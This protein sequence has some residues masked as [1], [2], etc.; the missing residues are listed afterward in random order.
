MG[1]HSFIDRVTTTLKKWEA[2]AAE[3]QAAEEAS[4]REALNAVSDL[5][6][7][8]RGAGFHCSDRQF[9][10]FRRACSDNQ[11][12]KIVSFNKKRMCCKIRSSVDASKIYSVT[13]NSCD[14]EDFSKSQL[15]LPCKHIYRLALELGI[16][17]RDWDISG[18]PPEVRQRIEALPFDDRVKFVK[19]I[20]YH[21][22]ENNF[23]MKKSAVP[24]SCI[25][26][27]LVS[28][29][30]DF[31]AVLDENYTKNDII[32]ALAVSKNEYTP[33]SKSTKREMIQWIID[34]DAKLLRKLRNKHFYISFAPEVFSCIDYIYR[35][36][37]YL[38][39]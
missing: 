5:F 7:N 19:L 6:I 12:G 20:P 27:G 4:Q 39:E 23:E 2:E 14:C 25:E 35:E 33:T 36:Y 8:G 17:D 11:I 1:L 28:E 3:R 34:N 13:L 15:G 29:S 9:E 32:A 10:R 38:T 24:A 18:I 21:T 30:S 26:N 16:I 31:Y 22:R 37:R